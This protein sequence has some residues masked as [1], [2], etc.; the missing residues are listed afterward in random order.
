MK[1][2]IEHVFGSITCPE[3]EDV[4]FDESFNAAVGDALELGRKL[5]RLDRSAERIVRHVCYEPKRDP[6]S[7]AGQ[8]FGSSRA[9]FIEELDYDVRARRGRWK[10]IPNMFPERVRNAGTIEI[11]EAPEGV[12]RIVRGEVKVSMF[13]FGGIIE[14]MIVAE[15][16]K[17][18]ASTAKLTT[19]WIANRRGS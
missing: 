8:A 10:T 18:Y 3:Y 16:E 17:S 12:R 14:R 2:A 1:V 19:E 15:I 9:S 4:Y 11:V 7:P 13:G 5:L 6:D